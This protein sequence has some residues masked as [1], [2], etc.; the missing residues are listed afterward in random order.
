MFAR[1]KATASKHTKNTTKPNNSQN[2]QRSIVVYPN[3]VDP[4][5]CDAVV[6]LARTKLMASDVAWRPD[7]KPDPSQEMRTSDGAFLD[8]S[9]DKDGVLAWLERK[10]A[11]VT[12]LPVSHGEAF[13][14]LRYRNGAHYDSHM[15]R[16]VGAT[17]IV[18]VVVVC[19]V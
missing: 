18:V 15:V 17:A 2:P 16:P 10:I 5:R 13:N 12:M 7:E 14:V 3:F 11:A 1:L 19:V 9:E 4:A 6:K 8:A